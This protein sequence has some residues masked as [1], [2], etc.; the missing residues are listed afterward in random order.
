MY[1]PASFREDST[2]RLHALMQ[3]HPLGLLVT[4]GARGL[5]AS[6]VPFLVYPDE[7]GYGVLRAHVARANPT[8]RS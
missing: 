4:H 5:M 1:T 7:G 6:P 2:V 3:A 8:G